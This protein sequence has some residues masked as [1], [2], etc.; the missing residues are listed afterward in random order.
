MIWYT[1]DTHF[2]HLNVINFCDRPFDDVDHMNS[3][4]IRLWNEK[5]D[6][7]DTVIILGDFA[8]GKIAE[9]L[10]IAQQLNGHKVLQLGNH[11]RPWIGNRHNAGKQVRWNREYHD[12]G[13]T[14]MYN[15]SFEGMIGDHDVVMSHFPYTG[16][17]H[18]EDRFEEFRPTDDGKILLH[19]H[20]HDGWKVNDRMINVGIDVWDYAPV[21]EPELVNLLD[22]QFKGLTA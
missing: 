21:S 9:T 18:D 8:M 11:D 22:R 10:P 7:D 1:A 17:S 6:P 19:G 13:F 16:D 2:G 4:L 15:M 3:E 5:V 20:V 12:V 14:L